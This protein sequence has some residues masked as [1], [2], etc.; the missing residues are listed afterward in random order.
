MPSP[1]EIRSAYTLRGV[2]VAR[3]SEEVRRRATGLLE[4]LAGRIHRFILVADLRT[5]AKREKAIKRI[6]AMSVEHYTAAEGLLTDAMVDLARD[7]SQFFRSTMGRGSGKALLKR[8]A[9][10][11]VAATLV[12]GIPMDEWLVGQSM[13][14]AQRVGRKIRLH[15]ADGTPEQL[16]TALFGRDTGRRILALN[17]SGTPVRTPAF[18]GDGILQTFRRHMNTVT[19]SSILAAQQTAAQVIYERSKNITKL[20]LSV[21]LDK[22]TSAICNTRAG[23]VWVLETGAPAE[24]SATSESYPGPPPYHLNCRSMI[25][26]YIDEVPQQISLSEWFSSLKSAQQ[27]EILGTV[28]YNNWRSGRLDLSRID[29]LAGRQLTIEQLRESY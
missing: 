18:Q 27:R 26:P 20:E 28:R 19:K 21:I 8:E 3:Y 10:G 22:R 5:R 11:I 7:E 29:D 15:P 2:N 9:A 16:S 14:L 17:A 23:A 12:D 4:S 13:E 6:T 24:E 1:E 25:I